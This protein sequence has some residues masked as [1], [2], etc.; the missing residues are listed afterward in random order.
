MKL[1]LKLPTMRSPELSIERRRRENRINGS[2]L[3]DPCRISR[4]NR[5]GNSWTRSTPKFPGSAQSAE[6][7]RSGRWR[8]F[9]RETGFQIH[10]SNLPKLKTIQTR[11]DTYRLQIWR[12]FSGFKAERTVDESCGERWNPLP[13]ANWKARERKAQFE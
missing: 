13:D 9:N 4:W 6:E 3:L 1:S 8:G 12:W 7:S 11:T 10:V 5:R 2:I